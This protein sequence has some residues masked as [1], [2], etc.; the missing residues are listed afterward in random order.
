MQNIII[1]SQE[2]ACDGLICKDT[3]KEV[4]RAEGIFT[5]VT[6]NWP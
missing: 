2:R 6:K 4:R 5:I 3:D 1:H